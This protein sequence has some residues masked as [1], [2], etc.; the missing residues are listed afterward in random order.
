LSDLVGIALG[1]LAVRALHGR[2]WL[3][4]GLLVRD[5]E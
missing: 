2:R 5:G 4:D 3:R 1:W